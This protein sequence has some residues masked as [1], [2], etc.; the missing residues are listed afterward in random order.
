MKQTIKI[1]VIG[2][3]DAH[4]HSH[5]ATN[6]AIHHAASALG[7]SADVCW[8]PTISLEEQPTSVLERYD[9]LWC[10]P[11]SPYQSME[12]ALRA[13]RFARERDYVFIGT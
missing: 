10:S 13:I 9:A 12:G 4:R 7:I 6:E 1:G 2:D 3:F 8:L 5:S 11:G